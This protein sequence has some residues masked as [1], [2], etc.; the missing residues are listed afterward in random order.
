M[1]VSCLLWFE[2]GNGPYTYVFKPPV[3]GAVWEV[4]EP[5]G[6]GVLMEDLRQW[7]RVLSLSPPPTFSLLSFP[8]KVVSFP[9]PTAT[10]PSLPPGS[11]SPLE[12]S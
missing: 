2:L 3:G 10:V 4:K 9:F 6:G 11:C 12:P 1:S 5:L 8:W 7:G